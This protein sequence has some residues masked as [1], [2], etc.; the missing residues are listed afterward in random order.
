MYNDSIQSYESSTLVQLGA[1]LGLGPIDQIAFAVAD[2]DAVLPMYEAIFGEFNVLTASFA[3]GDDVTYRGAPARATLK[4]ALGRSGGVEIELIEV[5]D[6]DAPTLEHIRAHGDGLHHVRFPVADL[7]LR[8][9]ALEAAGYETV[10]Y[11]CR[12]S[13]LKFAYLEGPKTL[14]HTLLELIEF[15]PGD[16]RR[17]VEGLTD[18]ASGSAAPPQEG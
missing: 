14:G 6:G 17:V 3:E 13:G 1:S 18:P 15:A 16:P 7:D 12:P 10:L 5:M 9:A 4:V 2:M 11:G 8:Q